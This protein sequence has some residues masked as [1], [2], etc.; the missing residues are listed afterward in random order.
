MEEYLTCCIC[1]EEYSNNRIP[2]VL[3]CGHTFCTVCI[4][5]FLSQT[6]QI[7][8]PFD[9]KVDSRP[10]SLI[11]KN[12]SL[13]Q[14]IEHS[15]ENSEFSRCSNHVTKQK[16]FICIDCK[17]EFCSKCL[18]SHNIHQWIDK[19]NTGDVE[20]FFNERIHQISVC[21]SELYKQTTCEYQ[22]LMMNI[23]LTEYEIKCSIQE[24]ANSL[25]KHIE[26][27]EKSILMRLRTECTSLTEIANEKI[28]Q[29]GRDFKGISKESIEKLCKNSIFDA[30]LQIES[31]LAESVQVA[32]TPSIFQSLFNSLSETRKFFNCL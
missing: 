2:L 24:K 10:L 16:R 30:V 7:S 8:C 26:N 20:N 17:L 31:A 32:Q 6:S 22:S 14:I 12:V 15:Q 5:N 3:S 29:L 19:K 4:S 27:V 21:S 25:K 1:Y 13:L 11:N 23:S 28:M 18:V 9:R